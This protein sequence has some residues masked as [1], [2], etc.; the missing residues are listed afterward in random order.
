MFQAETKRNPGTLALYILARGIL[1]TLGAVYVVITD[2]ALLLVDMREQLLDR[3]RQLYADL[4]LPPTLGPTTGNG[5][6]VLDGKRVY[7]P[8][9]SKVI[10]RAEAALKGGR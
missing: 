5:W 7:V 2:R 8:G 3:D 10:E 9:G 4:P 6:I 1:N